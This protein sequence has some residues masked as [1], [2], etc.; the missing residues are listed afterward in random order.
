MAHLWRL[1]GAK[2]RLSLVKADLMEN[3]SFDNAVRGCEGVFH[4]AS[5]V[6]KPSSDPQ[7]ACNPRKLGVENEI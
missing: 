6:I 5:P 1:E 2:E 4:T 3:E 7:V